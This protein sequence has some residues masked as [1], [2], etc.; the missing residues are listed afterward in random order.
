MAEVSE[1]TQKVKMKS[2]M[3]VIRSESKDTRIRHWYDKSFYM[4]GYQTVRHEDGKTDDIFY[5]NRVAID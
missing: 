5:I 4:Y 2:P 1:S 3:D